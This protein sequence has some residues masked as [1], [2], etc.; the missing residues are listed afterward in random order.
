MKQ[1]TYSEWV[2]EVERIYGEMGLGIVIED[3]LLEDY[4][5]NGFTPLQVV[6]ITLFREKEVE[7]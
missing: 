7:L 4:F 5:H 3:E 6:E 2:D 1:K